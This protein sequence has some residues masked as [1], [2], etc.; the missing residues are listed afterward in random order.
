[1]CAAEEQREQLHFMPSKSCIMPMLLGITG[2]LCLLLSSA[3]GAVLPYRLCEERVKEA[4][5][6][7]NWTLV[8]PLPR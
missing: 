3:D 7:A 8:R 4:A 5:V 6:A 1:M 2:F